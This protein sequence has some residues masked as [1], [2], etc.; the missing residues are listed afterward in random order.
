VQVV[1]RFWMMKIS[2]A[3]PTRTA[4]MVYSIL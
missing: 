1:Y 4:T 2:A 3:S